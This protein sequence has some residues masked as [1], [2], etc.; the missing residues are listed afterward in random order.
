MKGSLSGRRS[1]GRD[2]VNI[3]FDELSGERRETLAPA[4]RPT[5][6]KGD[7]V[8]FD[9][10]EFAQALSKNVPETHALQ[11]GAA[12]LQQPDTSA[13]L[14]ATLRKARSRQD[15]CQA[16]EQCDELASPH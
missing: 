11:V 14:V 6:L 12:I 9:I 4:I 5:L 13:L 16:A 3:Q 10:S 7:I 1:R 15:G 2:D 8:A